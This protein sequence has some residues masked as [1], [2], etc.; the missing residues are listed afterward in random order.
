MTQEFYNNYRRDIEFYQE[1]I[2]NF[3]NNGC[4]SKAV[5]NRW[6]LKIDALGQKKKTYEDVLKRQLSSL[7]ED[8]AMLR[9]QSDE[10]RIRSVHG[11]TSFIDSTTNAAA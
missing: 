9:M 4:N 10:L 3:I 1:K 2:Q 6:I 5:I 8:F 11:Q 7:D